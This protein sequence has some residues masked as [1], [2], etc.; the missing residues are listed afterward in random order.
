MRTQTY[1]EY[2]KA[3]QEHQS[4]SYQGR[5]LG[6]GKFGETQ[7]FIEEMRAYD[8][9]IAELAARIAVGGEVSPE[10][11]ALLLQEMETE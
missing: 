10:E 1:N 8:K 5:I 9:T 11:I 3:I 6:W 2:E 7:M 4:K